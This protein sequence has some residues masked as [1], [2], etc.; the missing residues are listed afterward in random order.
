[1]L[2]EWPHYSLADNDHIVVMWK[3]REQEERESPHLPWQSPTLVPQRGRW[4]GAPTHF[5]KQCK[6]CLPT[7]NKM[8]MSK[9]FKQRGWGGGV[10]WGVLEDKPTK[11]VKRPFLKWINPT[12]STFPQQIYPFL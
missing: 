7:V 1:M 9:A 10:D 11:Q 4:G 8:K 2:P 12:K 5:F 6:Q 3:R